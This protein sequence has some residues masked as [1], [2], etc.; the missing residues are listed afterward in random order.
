[1]SYT[2]ARMISYA[3]AP[4]RRCYKAIADTAVPVSG[5]QEEMQ[6]IVLVY[7]LDGKLSRHGCRKEF[8]NL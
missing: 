6:T 7:V 1:M 8:L 5:N 4:A 2:I 3:V